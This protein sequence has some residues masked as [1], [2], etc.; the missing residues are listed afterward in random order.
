MDALGKS[1]KTKFPQKGIFLTEELLALVRPKRIISPQ[2]TKGM[3]PI[4]HYLLEKMLKNKRQIPSTTEGKIFQKQIR[5]VN[6]KYEA[7]IVS[8]K[9]MSASEI[10]DLEIKYGLKKRIPGGLINGIIIDS[11]KIKKAFQDI[12]TKD[13]MV[14]I[15]QKGK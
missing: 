2:S 1:K 4:D 10:K 7:F 8:K 12:D 11:I 15:M 14:V 5:Q 6:K 9:V 3:W 13:F